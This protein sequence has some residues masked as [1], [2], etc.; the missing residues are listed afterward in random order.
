LSSPRPDIPDASGG[1][2][3]VG[4]GVEDAEATAVASF[5]PPAFLA[6]LAA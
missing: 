3:G 6:F 4:G 2:L 5:G 1:V